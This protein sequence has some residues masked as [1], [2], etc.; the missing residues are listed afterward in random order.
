MGGTAALALSGAGMMTLPGA[1]KTQSSTTRSDGYQRQL[2]EINRR[3][4][5]DAEKRMTQLAEVSATHRARTAAQ[6]MNPND[7]SS[8]AVLGG[9]EQ[10][11]LNELEAR[12]AQFDDQR[13]TAQTT[14]AE[15]QDENLIRKPAFADL[16]IDENGTLRELKDWG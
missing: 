1:T 11:T 4:Q 5:S 9:L 14:F 12:A 6:G 15:V 7:G 16:L 2:A 13:A 8:A 10:K 3:Q